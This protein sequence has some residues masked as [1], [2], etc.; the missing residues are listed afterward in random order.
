MMMSE[1]FKR[2]EEKVL[3]SSTLKSIGISLLRL[4]F[5]KSVSLSIQCNTYCGVRIFSVIVQ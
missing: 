1:H 2:L 3:T 4:R 5:E